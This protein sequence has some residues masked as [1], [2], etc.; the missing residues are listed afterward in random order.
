[1]GDRFGLRDGAAPYFGPSWG[2]GTYGAMRQFKRLS[3]NVPICAASFSFAGISV[4]DERHLT[5][6]TK[7]ITLPQIE[8][9]W[10][11]IR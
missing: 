8:F 11:A 2:S 5:C 7:S 6:P 4:A 9:A 3:F 1:M 10:C